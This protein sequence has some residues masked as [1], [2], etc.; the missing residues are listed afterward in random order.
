MKNNQKY[1]HNFIFKYSKMSVSMHN[2]KQKKKHR[3]IVISETRF[4]QFV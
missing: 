3:E 4:F 2:K 1:N